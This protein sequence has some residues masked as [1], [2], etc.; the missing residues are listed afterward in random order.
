MTNRIVKFCLS[1]LTD[2]HETLLLL[3][4]S[5][6]PWEPFGSVT[7]KAYAEAASERAANE[8]RMVVVAERIQTCN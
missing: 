8:K 4:L 6:Q 5:V 3:E 2:C 7:E 1:V